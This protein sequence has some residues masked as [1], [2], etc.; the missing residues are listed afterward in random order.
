MRVETEC[1]THA[2]WYG[3]ARRIEKAN[4]RRAGRSLTFSCIA[5]QANRFIIELYDKDTM[6]VRKGWRDAMKAEYPS[7]GG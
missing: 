7:K 6:I 4:L 5:A 3:Y 1:I 2:Q